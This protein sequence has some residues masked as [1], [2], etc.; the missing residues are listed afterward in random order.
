MPN[1]LSSWLAIPLHGTPASM[2]PLAVLLD[3]VGRHVERHVVHRADGAGEVGLCRA[4][5]QVPTRPARRRARPG[6]RRRRACR[7]RRCR[8]RSAGPSPWGARSSSP[9][10][11]PAHP[12]RSRRCAAMSLDTSARWL[13]PPN[14][15]ECAHGVQRRAAPGAALGLEPA[16]RHHDRT[17]AL[18]AGA[19]VAAAAT[20]AARGR[21]APLRLAPR[22][23]LLPRGGQAPRLGLRRPAAVHP[24]RRAAGPR[25]RAGQ[26]G[27][28]AAV[29]RAGHG[30]HGAAWAR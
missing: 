4:G 19:G 22:R 11:C 5:R 27:G 14:S 8:R 20:A 6:T 13:M 24:R 3:L 17:G 1:S 2:Q 26:P 18:G 28:A 16:D 29:P 21:G 7:R 25:A 10:A 15:K 9:A 23:A 30:R 12:R